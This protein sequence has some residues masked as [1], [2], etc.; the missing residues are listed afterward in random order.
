MPTGTPRLA[1]ADQGHRAD[2]RR[3]L[4]LQRHPPQRDRGRGEPGRGVLLQP[5]RDRRHRPGHPGDGVAHRRQRA[6]GRR[7]RRRRAVRRRRRPRGGPRGRRLQPVLPA[8]G[9][10]LRLRV[11]DLHPAAPRRRRDDGGADVRAVQPDRHA[12]REGDRPD[13]RRLRRRPGELPHAPAGPGRA[14]RASR[15][16]AGVAGREEAPSR[17]RRGRQADRRVPRRGDGE[18]A[19]VLLRARPQLPRGAPRLRV[20]DRRALRGAGRGQAPSRSSSPTRPRRPS[21]S[22]SARRTRC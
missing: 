12:P 13:R 17:R 20:E 2:G 4:L 1:H 8:H 11:L 9:R 7:R 16:P 10:P 18:V 5:P 3:G 19:R 14:P 15:R 22:S 6:A 21:R